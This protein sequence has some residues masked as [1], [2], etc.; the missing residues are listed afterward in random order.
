MSVSVWSDIP[1]SIK[2]IEPM[3]IDRINIL[4]GLPKN[5][6]SMIHYPNMGILSQ[7]WG[8]SEYHFIQ[9]QRIITSMIDTCWIDTHCHIGMCDFISESALIEHAQENEVNVLVDVGI[10]G[11]SCREVLKRAKTRDEVYAVIGIHPHDVQKAKDDDLD[12]I[13]ENFDHPK[14]IAIGE[15]G[16]DYY[17]DYSPRDMQRQYFESQLRFA[18]ENNMPVVIHSRK[19][20]DDTLSIIK[21]VKKDFDLK[22]VF[23]CYGYG[24]QEMKDVLDLG[25]YI[26]FPGALTYG[27]AKKLQMTAKLIPL[28]RALVETDAPFILPSKYKGEKGNLPGYVVETALMLAKLRMMTPARLKPVL[29]ENTLNCFPKLQANLEKS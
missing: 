13:A 6:L 15:M 28:D 22:G 8:I 9:F 2:P 10:D 20:W 27:N 7:F 24:E 16:L 11:K 1:I 12:F 4:N 26:S 5:M 3:S 21:E 29:F 19:A 14:V 25:F 23:H 17:R 18:G